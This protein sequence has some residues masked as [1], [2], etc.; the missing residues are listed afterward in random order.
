[1]KTALKHKFRKQH[2]LELSKLLDS[3]LYEFVFIRDRRA[4]YIRQQGWQTRVSL[5]IQL[6]LSSQD[7]GLQSFTVL[8]SKL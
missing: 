3:N 1:M 5:A 2:V 7:Q 4:N 8:Q 6:N